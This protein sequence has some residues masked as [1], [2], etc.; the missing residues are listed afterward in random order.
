MALNISILIDGARS[1]NDVLVDLAN[2]GI[3]LE[4]EE[5]GLWKGTL[6]GVH[7]ALIAKPDLEDDAELPLSRFG[8]QVSLTGYADDNRVLQEEVMSSFAPLV[9]KRLACRRG[10]HCL[11][12]RN[13]QTKLAEY[14]ANTAAQNHEGI[15][16]T[17]QK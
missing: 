8:V 17:N 9:A 7:I 14:P 2:E 1:A 13:L 10:W 16:N 11:V 5:R 12:V 15:D 3:V 4:S 6:G